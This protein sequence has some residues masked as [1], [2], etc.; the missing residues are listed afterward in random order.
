MKHHHVT[1]PDDIQLEKILSY[2]PVPK[3]PM[4]G[5]V[6]L[7]NSADQT[8]LKYFLIVKGNDIY[9]YTSETKRK[10]RFMHSLQGCYVSDL[11]PMQL[12]LMPSIS[13]SPV[14]TFFPVEMRLSHICKRMLLFSDDSIRQMWVRQFKEACEQV[15][16]GDFY[17]MGD[18]LAEG[19]FGKVYK[20]Y[21]R[22]TGRIVAVK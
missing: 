2:I 17:R 22:D 5:H 1:M 12:P 8:I 13:N 10:L 7:K 6:Y 20:G 19:S 4:E 15:E 3:K 14:E 11:L 16:F 9:C 18:Y 21:H